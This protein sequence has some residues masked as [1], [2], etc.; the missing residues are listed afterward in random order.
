[1][2]FTRNFALFLTVSAFVFGSEAQTSFAQ[3]PNDKPQIAENIVE[4]KELSI[5]EKLEAALAPKKP[6][7][8]ENPKSSVGFAAS[9][10]LLHRVGVQTDQTV[11]LSLNEAIRTAL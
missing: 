2:K 5:A 3:I 8:S 6:E 1:M 10:T 7:T 11:P 9:S 4:A